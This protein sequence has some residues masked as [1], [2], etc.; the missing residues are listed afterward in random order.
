MKKFKKLIPAFCA[1]LVSAAMLGTST[2]AWFSVNKEVTATGM[3]VTAV[4]NTQYFVIRNSLNSDAFESP[5]AED[6][7]TTTAALAQAGIGGGESVNVYPAA[8]TTSA[9]M[10]GETT[11]VAAN[12]WYTAG[13]DTG[14]NATAN[15]TTA[16]AIG[17]D[18][19]DKLETLRQNNYF[20]GYKFYVGLADKT[21]SCEM[22]LKFELNATATGAAKIA[23]FAVKGFA[24]K[25]DGAAASTT[26]ASN[27]TYISFAT[28]TSGFSPKYSF[29]A[30]DAGVTA[31]Y[32]EVIVYVYMDGT[33]AEIKSDN[34]NAS[35]TPLQGSLGVKVTASETNS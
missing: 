19:A 22:F 32:A 21:A 13:V 10:K 33:N 16:E 29:V 23:G 26:I 14:S 24:A 20:V 6:K 1:M 34:L 5:T 8:Y 28:A 15:I 17:T 25:T 12:K 27:Y 31:T 35:G 4:A 30:K 7:K 3:N 11:L 9:I 18:G 2:Y